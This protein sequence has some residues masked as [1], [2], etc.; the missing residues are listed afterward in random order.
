MKTI[1]ISLLVLISIIGNS[2]T[3]YDF[4]VTD[5]DGKEFD[6]ASLK[7]KKIMIV[8]TASKCGLTP[9]YEELEK[10]YNTYK[11]SNFVIVGFPSNDFMSQEP[12][13]NDEIKEFCKK[14]YGVSFPMMSKIDVKGKTMHPLY[15]FL[16]EK[17]KNGVSDNS[18]KWNF[19]KYLINEEGKLVKVISP[20]TKPLS[21]EIVSWIVNK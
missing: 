16:T 10:L 4:K 9:Q 19:Q 7:G 21:E 2:Q 14:N 12:G 1:L 20:S 6:L 5:I 11:D 13:S 3:I 17:S 8:N 18:V 15:V